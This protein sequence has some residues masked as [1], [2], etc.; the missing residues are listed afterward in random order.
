MRWNWLTLSILSTSLS[1]V[2]GTIT[3]GCDIVEGHSKSRD[4]FFFFSPCS[5]FYLYSAHVC[6][7]YVTLSHVLALPT[8]FG[9]PS[10]WG[11]MWHSGIEAY[12]F[13]SAWRVCSENPWRKP[14]R[15]QEDTVQTIC[16]S[17]IPF[18]PEPPLLSQN[19]LLVKSRDMDLF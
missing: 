2:L 8:P 15:T 19:T 18:S 10:S 12:V 5:K 6:V 9:Y 16:H 13:H 4:F 3:L 17:S 14:Q 7:M 11:F 1:N